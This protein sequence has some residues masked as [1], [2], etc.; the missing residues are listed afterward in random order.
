MIKKG[1]FV[2]ILIVFLLL[3]YSNGDAKDVSMKDIDKYLK[4]NTEIEQLVKAKNRD[5]MQFIGLNYEDFN[6][7]L[8]YRN[9]EA[10]SVEELLIIKVN[11]TKQLATLKNAVE[12]RVEDQI[13][14]FE[15]YGPNQV[16]LLEDAI[17]KTKGNYL[18]FC[19]SKSADKY[20]EV[21]LN[22]I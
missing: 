12:K 18:F 19:V 6:S 1:F 15:G 9:V 10:L 21:F 8:Y 3:I 4:A 14:T 17:I 2:V 13:S 5:L 16:A 11:S 7:H 20:E 22:V